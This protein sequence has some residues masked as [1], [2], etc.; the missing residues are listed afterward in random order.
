[1][2][3]CELYLGSDSEK[4]QVCAIGKYLSGWSR[5]LG[6]GACNL[7]VIGNCAAEAGSLERPL[8][9]LTNAA[10]ST[11]LRDLQGL[12]EVKHVCVLGAHSLLILRSLLK[13]F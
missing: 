7:N 2:T 3:A 5:E 6:L 8:Q 13:Y 9:K 1:M 10:F 4:K 12:P 11:L